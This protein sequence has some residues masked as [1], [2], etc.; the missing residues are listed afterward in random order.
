MLKFVRGQFWAY[1]ICPEQYEDGQ[2]T[3]RK[4]RMEFSTQLLY[5]NV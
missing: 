3:I 1:L 2:C 5:V 4:L